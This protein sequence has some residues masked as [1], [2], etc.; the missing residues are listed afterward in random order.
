[1]EFSPGS[2][3]SHW[4]EGV[5]EGSGA[6][7]MRKKGGVG[8][9]GAGT[10]PAKK[11]ASHSLSTCFLLI[12]EDFWLFLTSAHLRDC[13]CTVLCAVPSLFSVGSHLRTQGKGLK[14]LLT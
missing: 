7:P 3:W 4:S 12:S 8:G 14:A 10:G 2:Y 9:G 5:L 11:G 6:E 13:P 1:M